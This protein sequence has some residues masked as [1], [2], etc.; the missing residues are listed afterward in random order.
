MAGSKILDFGLARLITSEL[1]RS[2][3]MVGTVNYMAPEQ[4][5]GERAGPPGGHL[6]VR[7]AALRAARRA[8]ALSGRLGG[9]DDVQDPA[10]GSQG[11]RRA[12]PCRGPALTTL[13]DRA[14]A[15]AREDRYQRMTD[16]LRDLE[17]AYEPMRGA[18][19]RVISRVEAALATPPSSRS[20]PLPGDYNPDNSPTICRRDGAAPHRRAS[21]AR[22][23]RPPPAPSQVTSRRGWLLRSLSSAC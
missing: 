18:D 8:Q 16:L 11:A 19:R 5:R 23:A 9:R 12:R 2:N 14:M 4:L 10:R 13:V 22:R 7:R 1:T 6:L 15:K 20:T 3:V 17:A 21:A